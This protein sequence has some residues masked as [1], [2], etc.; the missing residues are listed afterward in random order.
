MNE[1]DRVPGG[2]HKLRWLQLAVRAGWWTLLI[3]VIIQ[4]CT[5]LMWLMLFKV[6]PSW[7]VTL[8]GGMSFAEI[9]PLWIRFV[10]AF[11]F[12]LL[13][14]FLVLIWATLWLRALR[15]EGSGR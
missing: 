1:V 14:L 10:A 9:R 7:M 11:K 4:T 12:A 5:W 6:Q 13:C 3:A 15:H 2:D 8:W